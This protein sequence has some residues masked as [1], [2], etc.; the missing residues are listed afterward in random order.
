MFYS[1]IG[2]YMFRNLYPIENYEHWWA[3]PAHMEELP[4]GLIADEI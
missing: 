4:A 3:M 1:L 2:G